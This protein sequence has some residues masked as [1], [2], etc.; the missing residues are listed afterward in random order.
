MLTFFNNLKILHKIAL[1]LAILMAISLG[2]SAISLRSLSVQ[3][4]AAGWTDHTYQ[5][6]GTLNNIKD[7][8][9]NQ[10]T[11]MRGYVIAPTKTSWH[12]RRRA[13]RPMLPIWP[14]FEI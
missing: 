6:L 11:G 10:E 8:M 12:R 3:Q 14:R 13:R 7:A 2:V 1:T 9:V 4:E 5:V